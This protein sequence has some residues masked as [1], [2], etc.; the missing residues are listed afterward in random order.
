MDLEL[1]NPL[2]ETGLGMFSKVNRMKNE[3]DDGE[4]YILDL[5]FCNE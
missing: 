1:Q 2:L 4:K 3:S 5:A